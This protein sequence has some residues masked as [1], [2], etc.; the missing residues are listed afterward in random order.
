MSLRSQARALLHGPYTSAGVPTNG[1][2]EVQTI[3]ITGTPTGGTFRLR[4]GALGLRTTA[5]AYNADAAAVQT[6]LN[7]L[8]GIGANGTVCAGGPLPGTPITVTFS[9]RN[10]ASDV[11]TLTVQAAALT[12]GTNPAVAVAVTTPGVAATARG[13]PPGALLV[14]TVGARLY[15]NQGTADAPLWVH[16]GGDPRTEDHTTDDTLTADESGSLHTNTGAT[17]TV[18]LTLPAAAVG[19]RFL[20]VVGAA[21]SL[22]IDPAGT[23]QICLPS[24]G[25]PGAAGKYL[26]SSTVGSAVQLVCGVPGVWHVAGAS[27]TWAAEA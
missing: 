11:P 20:F 27:G 2:S 4:L 5:I 24:T 15:Q 6:A 17:G 18:T 19:R 22:R 3:T 13:A 7:A 23:Q 25:V 26:G 10:A 8:A 21:Q 14:D 1:T 16:R 12:G 9:G